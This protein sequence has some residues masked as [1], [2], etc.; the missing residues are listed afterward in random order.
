MRQAPLHLPLLHRVWNY[1]S[2]AK[3]FEISAQ[4]EDIRMFLD[5]QIQHLSGLARHVRVD[6][7]L[8]G[9]IIDAIIGESHGM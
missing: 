7:S 1:F 6:S 4:S 8:K 5:S 9:E 3:K 2:A